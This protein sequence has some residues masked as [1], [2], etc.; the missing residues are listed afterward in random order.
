MGH[1]TYWGYSGNTSLLHCTLH[2]PQDKMMLVSSAYNIIR[3]FWPS[4]I[5]CLLCTVVTPTDAESM[6]DGLEN[7]EAAIETMKNE[8]NRQQQEMTAATKYSNLIIPGT[9]SGKMTWGEAWSRCTTM[10]ASPF[11]PRTPQDFKMFKMV[12]AALG[13]TN[14]FWI[15][16]SDLLEEGTLQWWNGEVAG[17]EGLVWN[18]GTTLYGNSAG[19]DCTIMVS[20]A[21]Y[22]SGGGAGMTD[23]TGKFYG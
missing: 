11:I 20:G 16:A 2:H 23:C 17:D 22:I 14:H 21:A 19:D 5:F 6:R 4:I 18:D 12:R 10:G 13:G 8:L 7:M 3:T 1:S 9:T 15:P